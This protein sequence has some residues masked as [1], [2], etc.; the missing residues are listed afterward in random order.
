VADNTRLNVGTAGDLVRDVDKAGVKTPVCILD[1]GGAGVEVL[2]TAGQAL[3]AAS[4]PV[5]IASNQAAVPVSNTTLEGKD[6][7]TQ[8]TLAA[9]NAKVTA[10]NTGAVVLAAG[11]AIAGKVGIDQTTPGTTNKVEARVNARRGTQVLHRSGITAADLLANPA[12]TAPTV[13]DVTTAGSLAFN[14]AYRAAFAAGNAQGNTLCSGVA[15][16]TTAN[17]AS[18][19]HGVRLTIPQVTNATYYDL[20]L[21]TDTAPKWVARITET[22]RAAAGTTVTAVGTTGA[23]G[24]N[25]AGTV[26][27]RVVGTGQQTSAQNFQ[28]STAYVTTATAY[29]S[30]GWSQVRVQV[31]MTLT[32][33]RTA[34]TL[35]LVPAWLNDL[36]AG[37]YHLGQPLQMPLASGSGASLFQEFVLDTNGADGVLLLVDA[38]T[39]QGASVDIS[40]QPA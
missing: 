19:T 27:I 33:L 16:Q 40:L 23:G 31:K 12:S 10:V 39:G 34:P 20:F 36:N 7:A 29:D 3:M 9:L 13:A 14:T 25:G 8:T 22:Q 35:I 37:Q 17:D 15:T 18:S 28:Q 6:F 4:L 21:S 26:D 2:L 38:I 11:T 32:D 30:T 24:P 1:V 5:V